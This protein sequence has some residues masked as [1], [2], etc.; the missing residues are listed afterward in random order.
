MKVNNINSAFLLLGSNMGNREE[1]LNKAIELIGKQV[2]FIKKKSSLYNTAAWGKN[3]QNDFLNQVVFIETNSTAQKLLSTILKIEQT[4]G[5]KRNEKWA[6]RTI[7]IDILYFNRE[8]LNSKTLTVPHPLIQDR[9]FALLPLSEI[10]PKYIHPVL[11]KNTK[12]LLEV[13]NDKLEVR[14]LTKSL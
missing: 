1:F 2:G 4:L 13:C 10:A 14:K 9:R 6:E 8:I 7:D 3:D 12:E 11:H 5:R